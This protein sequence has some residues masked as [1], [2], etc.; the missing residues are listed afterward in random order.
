MHSPVFINDNW[1]LGIGV[2]WFIKRIG[3][4][5]A[6][7]HAGGLPGYTSDLTLVLDRE[8]GIALFTNT[9]VDTTKLNKEV[10]EILLPAFD[11]YYERKE[12]QVAGIRPE[13]NKF[14]GKYSLPGGLPPTRIFFKNNRMW[15]A[16][17][18]TPPGS[19]NIFFPTEDEHRF[20]LRRG[21]LDGEEVVFKASSSG[22]IEELEITGYVLTRVPAE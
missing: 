9:A 8:L 14:I 4:H 18:A 22:T 7:C 16:T 19:E 5:K 21:D 15:L 12:N 3:D 1:S 17:P 10:V 20:V 13:W 11:A 2:G 6:I